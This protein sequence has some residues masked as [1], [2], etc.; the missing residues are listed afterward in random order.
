M[1]LSD[2]DYMRETPRNSLRGVT[3]FQVFMG[4]N[5][6][7]FVI[8]HGLHWFGQVWKGVYYPFGGISLGALARGQVWTLFSHS[9]VHG[10]IWHLLLNM[11]L[12]F[13]AGC[14][15]QRHFG[16]RHFGM[17]YMAS[18]IMG[19][20]MEMTVNGLVHGDI[21]T[22]LVGSSSAAFG[23]LLA[24]AV[25]LPDE[26]ITALLWFI[27]PV[28]VRLWTV[29]KAFCLAQLFLGFGSLWIDNFP[30]DLRVAYFAHLGGAAMGWFYARSLGYGGRPMTYASQWQPAPLSRR[31]Q[32]A[33]A[34]A[35]ARAS[36]DLEDG[37]A[38]RT[39]KADDAFEALMEEIVNPLLDKINLHGKDSLTEEEQRAL[40][41]AS[42]EMKRRQG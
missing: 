24:L 16:S 11:L 6:V 25:A 2:R 22:P 33:R 23:L 26:E 40:E 27:V 19:A 35:H 12:L 7:V 4:I 36:V 9:F 32:M 28:H 39:A 1:G 42:R 13:F 20:A 5:I 30:A 29:A 8:Q 38:A 10:D 21:L 34:R 17:I 18:A 14:G 15:V 41:R 31:P 37:A 3:A